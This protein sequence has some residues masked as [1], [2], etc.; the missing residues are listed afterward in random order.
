MVAD[1]FELISVIK[2]AIDDE[3]Q[4]IVCFLTDWDGGVDCFKDSIDFVGCHLV[5]EGFVLGDVL[6]E[7]EEDLSTREVLLG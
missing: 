4:E 3:V 1:G 2:D 5:P 7:G 6:V